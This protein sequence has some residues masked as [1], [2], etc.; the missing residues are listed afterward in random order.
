ME[1]LV[2]FEQLIKIGLA[3][4]LGAIVGAERKKE[5]KP[6]GLRT[7]MLVCL[8]STL[9]SIVSIDFFGGDTARI[10]AGVVTG[11]GFLGAGAIIASGGAVRGLTTAA[12]LWVIAAVGLAIGAGAYLLATIVATVMLLILMIGQIDR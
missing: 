6:A 5:R 8:G 3:I 7:Y 4:I 10:A 9:I 12:G 2:S 1:S 11:I